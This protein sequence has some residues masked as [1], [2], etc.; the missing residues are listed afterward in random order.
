LHPGGFTTAAGRPVPPA[1]AASLAKAA[2]L[3]SDEL[4]G[5]ATPQPQKRRKISHDFGSPA[6]NPPRFAANVHQA[7]DLSDL[8]AAQIQALERFSDPMD[9][10]DD[11]ATPQEAF[12]QPSL[13]AM[14]LAS[15]FTTG[16]GIPLAPP[17]KSALA[18]VTNLFE[19]LEEPLITRTSTFTPVSGSALPLH[20]A[21][22]REAVAHLFAD[23]DQPSTSTSFAFASG[24]PAPTKSGSRDTAFAIFGESS[25]PDTDDAHIPNSRPIPP[26]GNAFVT[27]SRP[28]LRPSTP[29]FRSPM[30]S[31]RTPLQQHTNTFS[32]PTKGKPIVIKPEMRTPTL[33]RLGVGTRPTSVKRNRTSFSTP[34]KDGGAKARMAMQGSQGTPVR[35]PMPKEVVRDE[36]AFDLTG[37]LP[38]SWTAFKTD[39]SATR[40]PDDARGVPQAWILCS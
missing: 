1:S 2:A 15:G 5:F 35:G 12:A 16:S 37:E 23:S 7:A 18:A 10:L 33:K 39:C 25:Q 40:P 19:D 29:S 11:A 14:P 26:A 6:D 32:V 17:S 36:I 9:E 3:F 38:V 31:I 4:D 20:P 21:S 27:P 34:F 28:F 24:S 22:S 8:D 13:G 30:P